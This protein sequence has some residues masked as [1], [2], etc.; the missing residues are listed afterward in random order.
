M[1]LRPDEVHALA[2]KHGL[3]REQAITATAIAWA[4]SGLDPSSV[5][6]VDLADDTWGP[7]VGLYQVRSLRADTGT[8]K[9]RDVERLGDPSFNTRSMVA[10]STGG[11]NWQPWSAWKSGSYWTHIAAVRAAVEGQSMEMWHP[12]ALDAPANRE[13]GAF[14]GVPTKIVL[15]TVEGSGRYSY[16]PSSYYGNPYWPHATIDPDGIHQHLPIDVSAF[17]LYNA[18]GGAETNRADAIQCEV[19]WYAGR[20]D[21]LPDDIMGHLADWVRWVAEQ[22]GTPLNFAEFRGDGSYG[23][24]A[25]QRFGAQEWLNFSGICGHQHVPENDHWDPGAFPV[26]RLRRAIVGVDPLPNPQ[27]SIKELPMRFTYIAEGEDY[28][29]LADQNF[30]GRLP[31]GDFLEAIKQRKAVENW[32]EQSS[33]FHAGVKALAEQC[34]FRGSR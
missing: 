9:E 4:E 19:L 17:A 20:I 26:E 31:F 24:D 13:G 21:E 34:G 8:G 32:G 30:H 16:D 28:V 11:T 29:Y 12:R 6:D 3:T 33:E 1:P 5:G 25:P 14:I 7:S 15:H 10:I 22:T 2:V 27:P 23:E 18:A